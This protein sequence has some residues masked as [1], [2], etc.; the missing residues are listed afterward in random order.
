[1]ES[2]KSIPL[3]LNGEEIQE[4]TLFKLRECMQKN[5]HLSLGNSYAKV[6]IE[7]FVKMILTDIARPD[8]SN[9]VA[10]TVELDSGLASESE[11]ETVEATL[12][13][14][15]MPPNQLRQETDQ[16]VPVQTVIDGKKVTKHLKYAPRKVKS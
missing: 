2:E 11:P 10:A 7:V 12:M 5:C 1:M 14:E 15:P 9:N 3:P 4:A 8:V 6:R 13:V 16:A